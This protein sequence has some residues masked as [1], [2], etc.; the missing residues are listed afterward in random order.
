MKPENVG[1]ILESIA[2]GVFTVDRE[3]RI[4][5]WNRAAEAI[6]GFDR[7]E[8][9]GKTCHEV[10]RT[11]VC[12]GAC[13][14]RSTLETGED[15][16][17]VPIT[18]LT[19]DGVEKPVSI[20]TAVLRDAHGSVIGG[21]ETFRDLSDLER[22]R[23]RLRKEFSFQDIISK[24]HRIHNMFRVLPDIAESESSVLIEGPSG[25]GKELFARALHDLSPRREGPFIAVNC[26]ALPDTLLESELFGYRRGAF[27]DARKDKPGRFELARGGTLFLDE[28]GDISAALQVKLLRVLQE[29]S[30]EPL[31]ATRSVEADVR[32]VAATNRDLR[33]QMSLGRFRDDL[34]YRLNVVRLE[35]PPLAERKED[36]PLL[37]EHFVDQL[38]AE[39]QRRVQGVTERA[40]RALMAYEY[41]GNIRELQN[42]IEH[43]FV[44]SRG[45]L[46]DL[47]GLPPEIRGAA[48][49]VD[50]APTSEVDPFEAAEVEVLRRALA[51]CDGH[52]EKTAHA[53]GIHKTTLL[54]KMKRLGLR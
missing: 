46:I 47:D 31:G 49:P 26:G 50:E 29:R 15:L 13:T 3:W 38:N 23:K 14:L 4:T 22:L 52:R 25:S 42:A 48:A 12:Q 27:T 35:L 8:T 45:E 1:V 37:V 43:G 9:I 28:I 20:S 53:L 10:F 18:I 34:Y 41:P 33:E 32:I 11:N 44:L 19:C 16:V 54:R 40:L 30:F 5:S 24:N 21:A 6:T 2:D 39:K 51:R 7:E 17:G 36:I